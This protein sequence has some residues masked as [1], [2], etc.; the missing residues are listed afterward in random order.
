MADNIYYNGTKLINSKDKYGNKPE[1]F[2]VDGNRSSGKTTYWYRYLVNRFLKHKE[3]F[4]LIY[5]YQ[6]ELKGVSDQFFGNIGSLFFPGHDCTEEKRQ[7]GAFYELFI[8]NESCGYAISLNNPDKIKKLSHFFREVKSMYFDEFQ[9]KKYASDEADNLISIHTSIAREPN[10]PVRY[11]PLY[12]SSNHI[13]SLNPYYKLLGCAAR[14]D[15]LQEGFFKGDGFV[16]EKNMNEAVAELQKQSPFLRA[17]SGSKEVQHTIENTSSADNHSF[18]ENI[19]TAN[20]D[21]ICNIKIGEEIIALKA[22]KDKKGVRFYFTKEYDANKKD[23]L[24]IS[25]DSHDETTIML[26]KTYGLILAC[27]AEFERGRVRFS[28]IETKEKAFAF[29]MLSW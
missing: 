1:I 21:Y 16:I 10:R 7:E 4:I 5:R 12:M 27:K 29:L 18:I 28:D 22:P 15:E 6:N 23:I 17:F 11:L 13:S 14:I 20:F 25:S 26:G 19:Q 8:D 24:A 2:I 9:A 3:K